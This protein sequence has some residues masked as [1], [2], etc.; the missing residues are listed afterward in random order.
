MESHPVIFLLNITSAAALLVW[1]VRLVRTGFE[2]AFGDQ[3]GLWLRRSTTSRP[4][5][6][7]CGAAA[8]VLLQSSTAVVVLMASFLSA[9]NIGGVAG[10]ALLLG[11]D[12]GSALVTQVLTSQLALVE[13][14]LLLAGVLIFLRA[15]QRRARQVGRILIG[16]ALIF[17]SLDLIRAASSPLVES[18][19]ASG[20]MA[21]LAR[22]LVT[23]FAVSAVFAWLV[24]SSVAAILLYATMA[25]QGVLPLEAALAMVLG[26]NLGGCLIA[27]LLTLQSAAS[28][29]RVVWLNLALRGGGALV[30]LAVLFSWDVLQQIPGGSA[31]QQAINLH[32]AFNLA[33]L[34]LFLPFVG[35][36]HRAHERLFPMARAE[37]NPLAHRSALDPEALS[38][39]KRALSCAVREL[40]HIGGLVEAMFRRSIGLMDVYDAAEAARLAETN[41]LIE[42]LSLELRLYLAQVQASDRQDKIGTRAFDL[43][44]VGAN[45]EAAADIVAQTIPRLAARKSFEKLTFSDDGW[46]E[47]TEFH[48]RVL[49]N[50]QLGISVL[51]NDESELAEKLVEEKD[52]VRDLARQL[53][54]RHLFRLQRGLE[55]TL[56]TSSIHLELLRAIK[57]VNTAFAMIAYPILSQSGKLRDSRLASD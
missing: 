46:Q 32:L 36:L 55:E 50:V 30:A 13:P 33:L 35:A 2:R 9:G 21:Y 40:V 45:L 20:A 28:V 31:G 12:V 29:R 11:A 1:A 5:A 41:A 24:H 34:L 26:A 23:A 52:K 25:T 42:R 3:L 48:E 7:G 14:L 43:A 4:S 38:Q 19:A 18:P 51:M 39:P 56:N 53:E 27:L 17:I 57:N 6:A 44:G 37:A 8:A 15:R 49:R 47:L 22:D 10:L 16:L 54:E